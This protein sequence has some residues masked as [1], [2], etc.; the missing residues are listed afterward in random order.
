MDVVTEEV[1]NLTQS[2]SSVFESTEV[3]KIT[4][5]GSYMGFWKVNKVILGI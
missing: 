3:H 5:A 1:Y 2:T 4:F